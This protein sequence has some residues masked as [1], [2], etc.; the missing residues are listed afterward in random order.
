MGNSQIYCKECNHVHDG[1]GIC[2]GKNNINKVC[3]ECLHFHHGDRGCHTKLEGNEI[4]TKTRE[5][6]NGIQKYNEY[7]DF[8]IGYNTVIKDIEEREPYTVTETVTEQQAERVLVTKYKQE[9]YTDYETRT[10]SEYSPYQG[11][12][13]Y[14]SYRTESYPV[15]KSRQV[16]YT[17]YETQYKPVSVTKP[18]TYYNTKYVK[19]AVEEPIIER[20]LVE[21]TKQLYKTETY[22]EE[23]DKVCKCTCKYNCR[24]VLLRLCGR[25]GRIS[26]ETCD[27]VEGGKRGMTYYGEECFHMYKS[28]NRYMPWEYRMKIWKYENEQEKIRKEKLKEEEK[29]FLAY[30]KKMYQCAVIKKQD[31]ITFPI[32]KYIKNILQGGEPR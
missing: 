9:S 16:S 8:I 7:E 15:Q 17:E 12:N 13:G 3:P 24:C 22:T 14:T 30:R 5:I 1:E 18:V 20:R 31:E 26:Y 29:E 6:P 23:V 32:I 19:K 25:D 28:S 10:V 27:H 4:I 21:K 2:C 11:F